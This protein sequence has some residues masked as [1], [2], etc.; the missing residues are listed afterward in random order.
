MV[1]TTVALVSSLIVACVLLNKRQRFSAYSSVY[2]LVL[3]YAFLAIG[4]CVL[5]PLLVDSRGASAL[6]ELN[7]LE[8]TQT[9]NAL[10]ALATAA[11]A[12]ALAYVWLSG[13]RTG[14]RPP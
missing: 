2:G 6:I 5:Y 14:A 1:F 12:G 8:R 10:L 11:V 3:F 4:G 7:E 13:A 9:M